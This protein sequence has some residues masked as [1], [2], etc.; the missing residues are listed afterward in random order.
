[1]I[2]GRVVVRSRGE[3]SQRV[4]GF[5]AVDLRALHL[6]FFFNRNREPSPVPVAHS[7]VVECRDPGLAVDEQVARI[8]KRLTP[9]TDAIA[10]LARR[11]DAEPDPGPGAGA[12]AALEIVRY[13]NEVEQHPEHQKQVSE[14]NPTRML[15]WHLGRDVLDFL[16]AVGAVLD[17]DEYDEA[18]A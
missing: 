4:E 11:L 7:W 5:R 17:V 15:G 13:F 6:G 18:D 2:L 9:H 10:A 16:Q 1:M 14:K 3:I 8:L 12:G